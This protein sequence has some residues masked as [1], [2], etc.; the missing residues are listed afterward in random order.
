LNGG[1][2]RV[3]ASWRT[4]AGQSGTGQVV[5]L[6][7]DT[8]YLYFFT[9][10]NVEAV[11]KV[12]NACSV[13]QR[14]WVFAGGL[15]DVQ[16]VITVTD[17]VTG[18]VKSYTNPQGTPF[19]PIQD[20]NA[21][22]CGGAA[23]A[24]SAPSASTPPLNAAVSEAT[25]DINSWLARSKSIGGATPVGSTYDVFPLLCSNACATPPDIFTLASG[26]GD[27]NVTF[28]GVVESLKAYGFNLATL[29]TATESFINN[30][31]G[32]STL[33]VTLGAP[34]GKDLFPSGFSGAAPLTDGAILIGG[35]GNDDLDWTAG[36]VV[37]SA[38]L[39]YRAGGTSIHGG[40]APLDPGFFNAPAPWDGNIFFV[41]PNSAGRGVN[42]VALRMV[43]QNPAT[44]GSCTP[45]ASSLCLRAARFRVEVQ[46]TTPDGQ[47]GAGRA[48]PLTSD[49]GYFWFFGATNVEVV[50]KVLD[51]C[52]LNSRFWVFAGGLTSVRTTITVTDTKTGAVKTYS[53]PQNTPFRPIQDSAAFATCP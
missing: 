51:G 26:P 37:Q 2:F 39:D 25:A 23:S 48:V 13:N 6:T 31:N 5:P 53:N 27:H 9:A 1:R 24:S 49:T 19:Q 16:T 18:A 38:T 7:A 21:F 10:A 34:T 12:L 36:H 47:S 45:S 4:A 35:S 50:L 33:S 28:D 20:T 46:W 3:Q 22:A 40:P 52:G 29:P 32:T 11:I 15:T 41:V 17:S 42:S 30:G 44:G 8:G 43:L 14:F